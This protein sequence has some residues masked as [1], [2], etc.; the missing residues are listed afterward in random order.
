MIAAAI[1]PLGML[2]LLSVADII[3]E[4]SKLNIEIV[5]IAKCQSSEL[6]NCYHDIWKDYTTL[7]TIEI[8]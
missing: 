7:V 3:N 5:S 4:Y 2:E 8:S 6:V 1:L